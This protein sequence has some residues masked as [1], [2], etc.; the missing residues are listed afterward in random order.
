MGRFHIGLIALMLYLLL[1]LE[2]E[3]A[4]SVIAS[5]PRAIVAHLGIIRICM[6]MYDI[7]NY[8]K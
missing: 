3:K 7:T 2:R 8:G 5:M 4:G 6:I 1:G